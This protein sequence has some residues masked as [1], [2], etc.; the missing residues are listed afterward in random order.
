MRL[1]IR[2]ES[3]FERLIEALA[4]D[5]VSASIHFKLYLDLRKSGQDYLRELNHSIA[6]WQATFRAHLDATLFRLCRIYDQYKTSL[7]LRNWLDT[8]QENLELFDVPNFKARLKDNP[9]V[10][11]LAGDAR[12]P[13]GGQLKEDIFLVSESNPLVK[14]LIK[15]RMNLFAHKSANNII[16]GKDLMQIYP[17]TLD[18]IQSL[19]DNGMGILNRYSSLFRAQLYYNQVVGHD[20]YLY[21]FSA[22]KADLD[23]RDA[24]LKAELEKLSEADSGKSA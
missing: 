15:L 9:F 6:F 19:L 2:D 4:D 11:S 7:S 10:E 18:E 5:L 1:K 17:I 21:V 8:I 20:D 23:R 13:E 12:K 3:D 14:N 24:V 16:L 22:I